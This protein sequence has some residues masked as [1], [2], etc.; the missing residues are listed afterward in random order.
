M[1]ATSVIGGRWR[2]ARALRSRPFA[3]LWLGQTIS[4][5]GD[6]AY[7]TALAWQVL[8]LTGSGAAMGIVL[9]ATAVPRVLFLLIG[10]VIADRLP[11]RLVM[12]WADAGRAVAVGTIAVLSYTNTLQFWQLIALGLL[13]GLSQ[14]FFLPAYQSI[15][16]QLV[17]I[18]ALPSAN[19]LNGLT[20]EIGMLA[21]PALGALLVAN[22][23]TASAFGFDALTFLV[24]AL[25][26]LAVRVPIK[27]LLAQ[28][29][30]VEAPAPRRGVRGVFADI[31]EGMGYVAASSWLWVTI[32]IAAF[33]NALRAPYSVTLPLHVR[34]FYHYDVGLY[35]AIFSAFAVGSILATLVVGQVRRLH[36]R[37]VVAYS[38]LVVSSLAM[39]AF[40]LPVPH[41][42][43]PAVTLTAG[44]L[45]GAGIGVFEIIWVTVLQEMIPGEKLGRVTS[46]DFVGS[47]LFQPLGLAAIGFLTDVVATP[48]IFF[49]CGGLSLL[50]NASAFFVRGIRELP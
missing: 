31:R 50:L 47:F 30:I 49:A 12:L 20:R 17:E 10:G 5:L 37:G 34:D 22:F 45:D 18:E 16:P 35:G 32:A 29:G 36:H 40:A 3:L 13:F 19:A 4:T 28:E 6:G 26:L 7:L 23:S 14:A 25:C 2:F 42:L 46:V 27:P 9:I 48:V 21:G 8:T 33:G 1:S 41:D 43:V 44:A 38:A 15:A 11:R 39:M 24:S